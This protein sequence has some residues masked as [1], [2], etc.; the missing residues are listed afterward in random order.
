MSLDRKKA[1][2]ISNVA[3]EMR[4]PLSLVKQ[5]LSL[6]LDGVTGEINDEQRK[7]LAT[8]HTSIE[9]LD[10]LV[11]NM[12]DASRIESGKFELEREALDIREVIEDV[13]GLFER[14]V[15]GAGLDLR[16][17]LPDQVLI[18]FADR[19][20]MTHVLVNLVGNA[21]KFTEKGRIT[22][23]ARED[24]DFV[25]C[26]VEDTG[27][28]IEGKDVPH[29]FDRF[30]QFG[31]GHVSGEK[32]VGLGLAIAKGI[33]DMHGGSIRVESVHGKGSRFILNLP[34]HPS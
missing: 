33:V 34:K 10:R 29:L 20:R 32:G 19:D 30:S 8:A 9:R 24:G 22:I 25:E 4:A 14:R 15:Q 3:H 7:C 5:S 11:G 17:E 21:F 28:G 2:V 13:E 23:S 27:M 18:V 16:V 26:V 6:V 31:D 1:D 12:L